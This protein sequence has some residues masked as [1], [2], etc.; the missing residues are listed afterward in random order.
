M[1]GIVENNFAEVFPVGFGFGPNTAYQDCIEEVL[2]YILTN[3]ST[4]SGIISTNVYP[5]DAPQ[6]TSLP[7]IVYDQIGGERGYTMSGADG[8]VDSLWQISCYES[9]PEYAKTLSTAVRNALSAYSGTVGSV[10]VKLM[11]LDSEGDI[12]YFDEGME[13]KKVY[14]KRL[15]FRVWYAE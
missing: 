14:A 8:L 11:L 15:D 1:Y 7:F 9:T 12:P 3:D 5:N 2:F 10:I 6:S 4:V 13:S